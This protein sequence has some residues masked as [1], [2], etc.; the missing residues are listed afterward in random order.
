M[1][2]SEAAGCSVKAASQPIKSML[3]IIKGESALKVLELLINKLSVKGSIEHLYED[4]PRCV[5]LPRQVNYSSQA[6]DKC[7]MGQEPTPMQ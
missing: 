6:M 7:F 2:G 1:T 4:V 5:H 3:A